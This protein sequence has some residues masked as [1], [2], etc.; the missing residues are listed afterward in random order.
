MD[1]FYGG[2]ELAGMKYIP[3][4]HSDI[5]ALSVLSNEQFGKVVRAVADYIDSGI[6]PQLEPIELISFN[7]L[8]ESALRSADKYKERCEK[9]KENAQKRWGTSDDANASDGMPSHTNASDGMRTDANDAKE[10][11]KAKEKPKEKNYSRFAPPTPDDVRQYCNEH[12]YMVDADQFVDFYTQKGWM[13]G[14]NRM[15]DWQAA[16]RTWV[17]RRQEDGGYK[18]TSFVPQPDDYPF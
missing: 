6:E 12:G 1:D 18:Q 15:K 13:V 11:E 2:D 14:K 17:R 16:V 3:L 9:N 8:K 10:K 4:F 5:N 7:L